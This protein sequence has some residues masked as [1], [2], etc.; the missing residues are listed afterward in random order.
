MN[1]VEISK[2]LHLAHLCETLCTKK[3][4]NIIHAS[5]VKI[6]NVVLITTKRKVRM[7]LILRMFKVVLFFLNS[8]KSFSSDRD[9]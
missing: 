7:I 4:L 3:A 1:I 9:T 2:L 8:I 5:A 6:K